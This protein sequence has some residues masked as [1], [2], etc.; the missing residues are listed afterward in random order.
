MQQQFHPGTVFLIGKTDSVSKQI[1]SL[2]QFCD[3]LSVRTEFP[4]YTKTEKN[5]TI[6]RNTEGSLQKQT[7]IRIY[8]DKQENK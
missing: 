8:G 6:T 3:E 5:I 1:T 4:L 7:Y 2:T